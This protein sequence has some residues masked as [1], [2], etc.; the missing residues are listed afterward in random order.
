MVV[1]EGTCFI[2]AQY[3]PAT[4]TICQTC[5]IGITT[6]SL[7]I[8]SCNSVRASITIMSI[9]KVKSGLLHGTE[10]LNCIQAL[11]NTLFTCH[12]LGTTG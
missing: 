11:D 6:K 4:T 9:E 2:C 8:C 12:G 10:V 1:G 7:Q 5:Y 3:V